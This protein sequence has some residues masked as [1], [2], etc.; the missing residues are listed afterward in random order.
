MSYLKNN[1]GELF[2][3]RDGVNEEIEAQLV[4]QRLEKRDDVD[5]EAMVDIEEITAIYEEPCVGDVLHLTDGEEVGWRC[6]ADEALY[7]ASS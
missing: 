7:F 6:T 1:I 5:E 3:E 2:V 4:V